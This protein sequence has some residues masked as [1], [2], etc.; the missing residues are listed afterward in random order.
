MPSLSRP[1][2]ASDPTQPEPAFKRRK[3]EVFVSLLALAALACTCGLLPSFNDLLSDADL[4]DAEGLIESLSTSESSGPEGPEVEPTRPATQAA[5]QSDDPLPGPGL[6]LLIEQGAVSMESVQANTS[7]QTQGPILT[8]QLTNL[9][10]GEVVAD[11]PCGLIFEPI[12]GDIQRMMVIQ[13]GSAALPGSGQAELSPYVI[14][15]DADKSAPEAGATY[16]IGRMAAGEL[17]KMAECLCE[18]ELGDE[19]SLESGFDQFGVQ[20][21]VWAV[22]GGG[23]LNS[24]FEGL[25]EGGAVDDF[26]GEEGNELLSQLEMLM[27]APAEQWLERC[28]I[29]LEG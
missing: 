29:Q 6:P 18:Y 20:F 4:P 25:P 27:I 10:S 8:V 22:S 15:I 11:V 2:S 21:A 24:F 16:Q 14:C 9:E 17:L 5:D 19:V 23:S 13:P 12:S 26:L 7:G 1:A 3:V 28:D